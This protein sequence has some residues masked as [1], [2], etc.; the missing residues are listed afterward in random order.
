MSYCRNTKSHSQREITLLHKLGFGHQG[1]DEFSYG[2]KTQQCCSGDAPASPPDSPVPLALVRLAGDD[3]GANPSPCLSALPPRWPG[4]ASAKGVVPGCGGESAGL[5]VP[6]G[7]RQAVSVPLMG[8]A[9]SVGISSWGGTWACASGVHLPARLP[10]GRASRRVLLGGQSRVL[11]RAGRPRSGERGDA[12]CA[13]H[14]PL[15]P[16]ACSRPAWSRS[17]SVQRHGEVCRHPKPRG[18]LSGLGGSSG[19]RWSPSGDYRPEQSRSL[20][21]GAHKGP[22]CP[23]DKPSADYRG[24]TRWKARSPCQHKSLLAPDCL[25]M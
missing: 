3:V 24:L 13:G 17:L 12:P 1:W 19:W 4:A 18:M 22:L 7:C 25:F 21:P 11:G 15:Q 5:G 23:E 9:T 8:A 6:L 16:S 14:R 20:W 10:E 2:Q